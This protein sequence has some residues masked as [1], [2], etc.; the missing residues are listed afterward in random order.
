MSWLQTLDL[1][2]LH[3]VRDT[4]RNPLFDWLMP[5]LSGNV[6]FAPVVATGAV[7]LPWKGGVRGRLCL[8]MLVVVVLAGDSL[9]CNPIKRA[10]GR[11]RPSDSGMSAE[12]AQ[13][14]ARSASPSMPSSHAANLFSATVV[15][16]LYF[17][18]SLWFMLPIA[19]GVGYSRVYKGAHYP[20]D[21][22]VGAALGAGYG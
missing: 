22:L 7:V 13:S 14:V 1:S 18:R 8:L 16:F 5:L 3:L 11:A 19:I 15:A 12:Y 6:L 17:R 21:V 20:S 4:L 10:V 9:I 2:T